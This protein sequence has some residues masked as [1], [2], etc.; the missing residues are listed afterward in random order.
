MFK[1]IAKVNSYLPTPNTKIAQVS[2]FLLGLRY[3]L[4][5]MFCRWCLGFTICSFILH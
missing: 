3:N 5:D 1:K 4:N 2:C